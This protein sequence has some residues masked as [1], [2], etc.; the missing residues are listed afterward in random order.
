MQEDLCTAFRLVKYKTSAVIRAEETAVQEMGSTDVQ[1]AD[2]SPNTNLLSHKADRHLCKKTD[3]AILQ[4]T[5]DTKWVN[6]IILTW[7]N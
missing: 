4:H 5:L 6:K 1:R 7:D 3:N 2:A